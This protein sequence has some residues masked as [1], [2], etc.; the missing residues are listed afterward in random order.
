MLQNGG[1]AMSEAYGPYLMADGMCRAK[2]IDPRFRVPI[3]G[4]VNV[5]SESNVRVF[6]SVLVCSCLCVSYLTFTL[7][8]CISFL[9]SRWLLDTS[10]IFSSVR[11]FSLGRVLLLIVTVNMWCFASGRAAGRAS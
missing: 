10:C 9:P 5:T 3:T 7:S 6:V 11:T 8:V 2:E 4:Y 1:I